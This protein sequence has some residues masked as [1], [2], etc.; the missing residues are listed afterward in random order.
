[1]IGFVTT[2]NF[3]LG[4]GRGAAVGNVAVARIF[5]GGDEEDERKGRYRALKAEDKVCVVRNAG[6]SVGRLARWQLI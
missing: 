4:A 2:G 5:G 3:D 1:M 6:Q